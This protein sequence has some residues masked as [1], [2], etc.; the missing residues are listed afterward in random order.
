MKK[1][2]LITIAAVLMTTTIVVFAH[3][4]MT[5]VYKGDNKSCTYKVIPSE[6]LPD[7]K[8]QGM[9]TVL[10]P[11]DNTVYTPMYSDDGRVA[12]FDNEICPAQNTVGWYYSPKLKMFAADGRT[13]MTPFEE[14]SAYENVNW[15]IE[16]PA[17]MV[18][19]G[20]S[21]YVITSQMSQYCKDG[22]NISDYENGLRPLYNQIKDFVSAKSGAYGI[23]IKNLKNG[24]SL[25]INDGPYAGASI[26]KLFVMVGIY[27]G[28]AK[29]TVKNTVPL[30]NNVRKMITISD[31]YASNCLV[32]VIGDGN[33]KKGFDKENSLTKSIG[34]FNTQHLTLYS[35]YGEFVSYGRNLTSPADCG[36]LL[37]KLYKGTLISPKYSE[38][39]LSLLKNQQRRNKIP[40]SLPQGTVCANKTGETDTVQSDVGIVFSPGADYIICVLTNNAPTG[41]EDIRQISKMT[42][43]HFN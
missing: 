16:P 25:I 4:T 40:Y 1:P 7:A 36:L 20:K 39:M 6:Q 30:Q 41:I 10:P 23:Y 18:K 37:E 27:D 9:E 43:E 13:R 38:E 5:T 29:G 35:G 42:Y 32:K 3:G 15:Y 17:R 28:I 19:D 34:C 21:K 22:W 24:S 26:M 31:N 33:Y 12:F 11:Y 14:I 2:R 8:A